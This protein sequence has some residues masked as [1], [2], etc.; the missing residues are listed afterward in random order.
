M[1]LTLRRKN[2]YL[3][4]SIIVS[5]FIHITAFGSIYYFVHGINQPAQVQLEQGVSV[6]DV[7]IVNSYSQ[8]PS[9]EKPDTGCTPNTRCREKVS[10]YRARVVSNRS[11]RR[12]RPKGGDGDTK[13][14]GVVNARAIGIVRP[15]YPRASRVNGEEGSVTLSVLITEDGEGKNVEVIKSSGFARL[16]NA[17]I[18][19]LKKATFT[20]AQHL[21]IPVSTKKSLTF[22]FRLDDQS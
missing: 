17:A 7:A 20:P 21:G 12:L 11:V 18:D 13:L 10:K 6:I 22:V 3:S 19:A 2:C 15:K 4:F 9:T 5:A 16:D 8:P 14:K 1:K